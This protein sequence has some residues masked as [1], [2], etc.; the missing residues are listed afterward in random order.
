MFLIDE[1]EGCVYN[2]P[3]LLE[4]SVCS[5]HAYVRTLNIRNRSYVLC[6]ENFRSVYHNQ[7]ATYVSCVFVFC[8]S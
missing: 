4:A 7:E 5:S 8:W 2:T 1:D 3:F 6:E